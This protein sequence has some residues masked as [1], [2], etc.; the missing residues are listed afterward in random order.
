MGR[1]QNSMVVRQQPPEET[2]KI[3]LII[4]YPSI[5]MSEHDI[6]LN[7]TLWKECSKDLEWPVERFCTNHKERFYLEVSSRRPCSQT[8]N[9]L[10]ISSL[11]SLLSP[12]NRSLM[13]YRSSKI[14]RPWSMLSDL[15]IPIAGKGIILIF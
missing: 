10:K 5:C 1:E 6:L 2:R 8:Q 12:P 3:T 4:P 14:W 15:H 9:C 11:L 7:Q 13:L